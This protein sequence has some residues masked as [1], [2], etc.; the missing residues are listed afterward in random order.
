MIC[1]VCSSVRLGGD[2]F[3]LH[4]EADDAVAVKKVSLHCRGNICNEYI[5]YQFY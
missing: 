4:W 2:G 5:T 3:D 1:I